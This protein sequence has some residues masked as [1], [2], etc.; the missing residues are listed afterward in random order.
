M[1]NAHII[2]TRTAARGDEHA[3]SDESDALPEAPAAR[4]A[5]NHPPTL[6]T[7]SAGT[8]RST[9]AASMD[10]KAILKRRDSLGV[11]LAGVTAPHPPAT[12]RCTN[13]MVCVPLGPISSV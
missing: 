5:I 2:I 4:D 9:S 12:G 1:S 3:L 6:R 8:T 13:V 10:P 7:G 11:M